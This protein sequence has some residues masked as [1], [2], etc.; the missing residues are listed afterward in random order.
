MNLRQV[1]ERHETLGER[2]GLREQARLVGHFHRSVNGGDGDCFSWIM[3]D[4]MTAD[5][6]K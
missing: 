5:V 6:V 1:I 3:V 2:R 4:S